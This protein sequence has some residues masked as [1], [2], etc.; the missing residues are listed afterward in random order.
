[1]AE[2]SKYKNEQLNDIQIIPVTEN[3]LIQKF[4]IQRIKNSMWHGIF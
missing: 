4:D 3:L 2:G 1:M